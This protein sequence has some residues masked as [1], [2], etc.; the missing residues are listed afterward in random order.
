MVANARIQSRFFVLFRYSI[1]G[2]RFKLNDYDITIL[3]DHIGKCF[4][5]AA[6]VAENKG[7]TPVIHPSRI[8]EIRK[9][10]NSIAYCQRLAHEKAISVASTLP[11]SKDIV[12]AADTVVLLAMIYM[13]NPGCTGC[14][15]NA[16]CSFEGLASCC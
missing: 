6:G 1:T 12:V 5:S 9:R 13:R 15:S 8:E 16:F 11:S 2:N 14:L 10:R 4:S 3:S 7:F